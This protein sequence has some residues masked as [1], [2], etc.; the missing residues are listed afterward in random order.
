M[1]L[2][3]VTLNVRSCGSCGKQPQINRGPLTGC[4]LHGEPKQAIIVRC[5]NPKCPTQPA[6]KPIGDLYGIRGPKSTIGD[7]VNAWNT[8]VVRSLQLRT[9]R[10]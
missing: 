1:E 2:I 5:A 8:H 4:Q 9:V 6:T 7:A 3:E 10:V